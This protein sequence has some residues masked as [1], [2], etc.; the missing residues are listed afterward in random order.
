[1]REDSFGEDDVVSVMDAAER[2]QV[3]RRRFWGQKRW[4]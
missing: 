1:M 4:R 2:R 3:T